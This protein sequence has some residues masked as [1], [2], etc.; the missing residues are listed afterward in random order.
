M[1]IDPARLEKLRAQITNTKALDDETRQKL[2]KKLEKLNE[3]QIGKLESTITNADEK[4]KKIDEET[5]KKIDAENARY[6]EALKEFRLKTIPQALKIAEKEQRV[7]EESK[8]EDLLKQ[9]ANL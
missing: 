5:Q 1:T 8:A 3:E 4:L 9:A 7:T 6:L 2:L